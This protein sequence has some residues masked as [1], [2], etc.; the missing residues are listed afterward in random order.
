MLIDDLI[1]E[2]DIK[3]LAVGHSQDLSGA[4]AG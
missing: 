2:R 4:S 3:I 1:Q